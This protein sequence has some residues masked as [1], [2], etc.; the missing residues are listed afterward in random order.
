M[1]AP[2]WAIVVVACASA[3]LTRAN[4]A[5]AIDRALMA[6]RFA[7]P[8]TPDL[9]QRLLDAQEKSRPGV[10]SGLLAPGSWVGLFSVSSHRT[11]EAEDGALA[12]GG[13]LVWLALVLASAVLYRR[14][15]EYLQD[16]LPPDSH[17]PQQLNGNWRYGFWDCLSVPKMCIFSLCCPVIR[18]SDT[19]AM[20][21]FLGFWVAFAL[22][23]TLV[24]CNV[25]V[26]FLLGLLTTVV[27]VYYRQ[28]IRGLFQIEKGTFAT[29]A[30]DI[31]AYCFCPCLAIL[32][33]GRVLEEAYLCH[34]E[35]VKD[36]KQAYLEA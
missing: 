1:V 26:G 7:V 17:L 22:W 15:K 32:Q 20:A 12:L 19:A 10:R 9:G 14:Y 29:I 27:G 6:G 5:P 18:W 33:E 4:A 11:T 23:T 24:I 31:L 35:A 28:R 8:R 2:S 16:E 30:L 36:A 25:L 3:R 21:G 13:L 34:H